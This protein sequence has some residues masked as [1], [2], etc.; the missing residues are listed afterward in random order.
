[1]PE[2]MITLLLLVAAFASSVFAEEEY[3]RGTDGGCFSIVAGRKATTDGSVLFGHNEDNGFERVAGMRKIERMDHPEGEWVILPGGGRIQQVRTT[4]AYWW[5]QMPGL[6]YSDGFLNEH[7][8]AIVTNQCHSREDAPE[9]VDGG[10]GGVMLRRLVME[11]ARTARE[12]VELVG[13]LIDRFGYMASGRTMV[14]CDTRE[15]WLVAMVNGRHWMAQRVPDDR[16]AVISNTYS[17][18]EIDLADTRNFLGAPDIIDYAVKRGWYDPARG[19]FSFEEAYA[20]RKA[21]ESIDNTH[22]HWSALRYLSADPVPTPEEARLPF[23]VRPKHKLAVADIIV[24]LRDHYENTPYDPEPGYRQ[25]PAH[26]RHAFAICGPYTNSSHVFQLRSGMPVE[27]GALWW[28]AVRQPCSVPYVPFYFGSDTIPEQYRFETGPDGENPPI[29]GVAYRMLG[30]LAQWV[31]ADYAARIPLLR[32]RFDALER[33]CFRYQREFERYMLREWKRDP[34]YVRG[35]MGRYTQG[36]V[37]RAVQDAR[38][39]MRSSS[40]SAEAR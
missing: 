30:D 5:M 19:P 8:V 10:I 20:D 22:R 2:K 26:K 11:R 35:L 1:M 25:K 40:G 13:S 34:E 39:I 37:A 24:P 18:R 16:V 28:V 31:D 12:G 27:I 38:E 23:A 3:W 36:V 29:P 17:I 14:I 9:L 21:R 15:G 33:D 4:W 6:E 7:G 32:S